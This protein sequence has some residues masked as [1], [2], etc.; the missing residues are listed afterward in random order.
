MKFIAADAAL[1]SHWEWSSNIASKL[2]IANS[3]QAGLVGC[4]RM[5]MVGSSEVS[6]FK[7]IK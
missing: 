1:R 3:T 6:T 4:L 2:D 7:F 5:L